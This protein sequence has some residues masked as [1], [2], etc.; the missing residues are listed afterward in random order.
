MIKQSHADIF[1]LIKTVFRSM[2]M[3]LFKD[4]QYFSNKQ[5]F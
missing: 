4:E 1:M 2:F 3:E 5:T